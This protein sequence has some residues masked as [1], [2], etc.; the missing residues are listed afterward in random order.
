MAD[1]IV[2]RLQRYEGGD[3]SESAVDV[4]SDAL[5]EIERLRAALALAVGELSTYGPMRYTSPDQLMEHFMQ[6]A[7]RG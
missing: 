6:E 5:A 1:D 7:R 4:V 2:T 3:R